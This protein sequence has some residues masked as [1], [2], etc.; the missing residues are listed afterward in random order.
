MVKRIGTIR[1][2]TR[3]KLKKALNR[4][5]KISLHNYIQNLT[6]GDRVLLSA[7][8]SIHSGMYASR[9]HGKIGII[10]GKKGN[11]YSVLIRDAK[12]EKNIIV[13]PVHLKK[14]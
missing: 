2:K 7:D 10:K 4:R 6:M 1:R 12:K 13:H 5:G 8:S 9:F 3:H 11:C 14:V